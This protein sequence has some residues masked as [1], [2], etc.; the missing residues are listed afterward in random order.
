MSSSSSS[1]SSKTAKTSTAAKSAEE[2]LQFSSITKTPEMWKSISSAIMTIVDE[3]H[4]EV[5]QEGIKFRSMDPSHIALVDINWPSS[6]FEKFECP[7]TI[8]FGVRIDEFSKILRRTNS[9]DSVEISILQDSRLNIKTIG[10]GYLRNYKMN[11]IET[12]GN[13]SSTPLPQMT[14]DSKIVLGHEIFEKILNDIAVVSEQITIEST[15]NARHSPKEE[16]DNKI[17]IF[18]GSSDK[19]EVKVTI[20]KHINNSENIHEIDVKENSKSSYMLDY[21]S[22]IMRSVSSSSSQSNLVTIIEHSTK[23]PLRLEFTLP[24]AVKLQFYLAPRIQED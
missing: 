20:D 24:D 22:K 3:A 8:R 6:S 19:G 5:S 9:N 4:F 15:T 11:L 23:K 17:T 18:S 13:P 7:S 10:S 16:D 12:G 21:I 14:F 2:S 1:S